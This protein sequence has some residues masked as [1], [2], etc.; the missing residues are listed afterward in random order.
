MGTMSHRERFLTAVKHGIPDRVPACPCLSNMVPVRRLGIPFW[1]VYLHNDPPLWRAYLDAIR[2]YGIDGRMIY[3]SLD[4]RT[5]EDNVSRE[6]TTLTK[7]EERIHT[8]TV[9]HTP[10]GDLSSETIYAADDPPAVVVKLIKNI[11]EDM[12]KLRYLYPEYVSYSSE[13]A[14]AMRKETGEDAV[15]CLQVG[16]PGF[17]NFEGM[18]DGGLSSAVYAFMEHPDL[19]EEMRV[20]QH[21]D[22]VAK[23]RMMLDYKPDILYLGGSGTLTLSSP[24]WVREFT[25]PTLKVIT[26]MAKEAGVPTM[27]HSCGRSSAFLEMLAAETDLDCINPLEKPPMGDVELKDV[28][29]MYG[30]R[31]SLSGNIHTTDVML[32]G[33][34]ADVDEACRRAIEDAAAGGGFILMTGDQCGRDTPDENIFAFVAAAKKYGKY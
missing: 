12:P 17:H 21:A 30:S 2:Y 1:D 25:L 3:G 16:Y 28:K 10:L 22:A 4:I 7:T 9:I 34:A 15:F 31:L 29:E 14:D 20:L 19:F 13:K 6:T 5:R 23:A 27:L 33:T 8:R 32:R 18:F 26:R 24:E 11:A